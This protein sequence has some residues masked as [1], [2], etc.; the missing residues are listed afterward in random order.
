[1]GGPLNMENISIQKTIHVK[2]YTPMPMVMIF[3][4]FST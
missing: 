2:K 1:M 3:D 4:C